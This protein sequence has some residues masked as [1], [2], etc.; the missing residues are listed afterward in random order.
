[1]QERTLLIIKPDGVA[2]GLVGEISSRFERVGLKIVAAKFTKADQ[3]LAE[4]HYPSD[5]DVW[6]R[7]MGEKT[8]ENYKKFG[9]D[10]EKLLGTTDTLKIG[11]IIQ[12]WLV[13]YIISGP[14]LAFVLEGPHA[15]DLVRKIC[16]HTLP[17]EAV[18]GTIRGD[19]AY[20]S[21]YL[22][23]TGKRAIKNLVHA[24]GSLEEAKYEISLWFSPSEIF[25]YERV[26]EKAMR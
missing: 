6:L 19:L 10:P 17:S 22:A 16:G 11:K 12:G 25:G 2:R 9:V 7:G 26:E 23:N 8:L 13:K 20:D 1:M 4:K 21:S 14:V 5:R 15:V 3:T 18:P 24:S